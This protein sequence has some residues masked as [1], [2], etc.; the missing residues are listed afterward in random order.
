MSPSSV[1]AGP[2]VVRELQ[3]RAARALPALHVEEADGWWLRHN[4]G[5]VWWAGTVLPHREAEPDE[6]VHRI[7]RAERFYAARGAVARFQISPGACPSRLDAELARRGY[8]Q[9]RLVS[10][11]MA[12]TAQ[13][14]VRL[15]DTAMRVDVEDRPT[16]TWFDGWYAVHGHDSDPGLERSMLERVTSPSG[17]AHAMIGSEVVAVGR[18]VIDTGWA[19]LFGM[20][21]LP[22]ARGKGAA[23]SVLAALACWADAHRADH[24]Y[25]Q[26]EHD[27]V[28]ALRLYERAGFTEVCRYHHRSAE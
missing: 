19:G 6:L 22:R 26:V 2:D 25:L 3:E 23:R 12:A 13:V 8:R 14:L 20:A 9:E 5:S 16:P 10:L 24:M 15:P 17:Y 21:T 18:A 1:V 4:P 27:N 7:A 28:P 11:R